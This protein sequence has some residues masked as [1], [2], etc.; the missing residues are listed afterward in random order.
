MFGS[1]T[2]HSMS[3]ESASDQTVSSNKTVSGKSVSDQTVSSNQTVS[4]QTMSSVDNRVSN[5][6]DNGMGD[7]VDNGMG[8]SV[9]GTDGASS[10]SSSRGSGVLG[11]SRVG[12][13]SNVAGVVVSVVVD[14]LDPAVGEV[15]RVGSLNHTGAIVGLGLAEGSLGVV[16]SDSVVVGV[17]GG[18]VGGDVGGIVDHG[19]S[20]VLGSGDRAHNIDESLWRTGF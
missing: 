20:G 7:S 11:L 14:G 3:G 1:L 8:N 18:Q 10:I 4:N 2:D 13:L 12:H 5:S 16:V 17:G 15:D 9:D 19:G 6:A